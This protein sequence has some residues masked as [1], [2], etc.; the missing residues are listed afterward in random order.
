MKKKHYN[1]PVFVPHVGCPHDCVFC[2][3]RHITGVTK[4][5][6]AEDVASIIETHL[7]YIKE[8][9]S[10]VEVAFFGGS[11]TGIDF[12]VQTCLLQAAFEYVKKGKVNSLRCSTRPDCIDEK[13][14]DNL[15]KYGMKT[16]ELGVQS[17]DE[18]VLLKSGR[19]HGKD[20][21]FKASK[22]IKDYGFSLGLQMMLGLPGDTEEKS[23]RTA[24]DIISLKPD[25]VRIYP[26]LVVEDTALYDMYEKGCYKPVSLEY[27]VSLSAKLIEMF[28]DNDI[29]VIRVGLQ[30]TDNINSKTVVGPYHSAMGELAFARVY[31]NKIERFVA[32]N[33]IE[34]GLTYIVPKGDVSKALGHK[35]ENAIYFKNKYDLNLI[36]KEK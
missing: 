18:E 26:T 12:D 27:A 34:K 11:F 28:E 9:N 30:E 19:G 1:I 8:S 17:T 4:Q 33:N 25:C 13:I 21:I 2:N 36:I 32:E 24:K 14:L 23:I 16:I 22:L 35:K 7:E 5:V 29:D 6:S 15:K 10:H 20:A 3:Q 31:R